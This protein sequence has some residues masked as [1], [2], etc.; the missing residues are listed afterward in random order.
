MD[1]YIVSLS[2][3]REESLSSLFANLPQRCVVLLEDVDAVHSTKSRDVAVEEEE[4]EEWQGRVGKVSLS[5]LLNVL[6]GVASHEGRVLIMTTN[7]IEKLDAALVR[8]GRVDKRVEFRLA[9][10]DVMAQLFTV[11]FAHSPA[12]G[13]EKGDG[14]DVET[15]EQLAK[16]FAAQL[17]K[18]EF[19]PA[20]ILSL[21]LEHKHS[22]TKAGMGGEDEEGKDGGEEEY[23]SLIIS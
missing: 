18:E 13:P 17:P 7:H 21:L 3:I 20:E 8:P 12:D 11:V 10:E 15:V 5:S 1:I 6:D 14:V 2:G 16:E 4:E 9:N 23:G 19:S 22:A